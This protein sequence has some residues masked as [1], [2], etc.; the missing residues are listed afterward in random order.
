[1]TNYTHRRLNGGQLCRIASQ[2]EHETV[3]EDVNGK[4]ETWPSDKTHLYA[5]PIASIESASSIRMLIC[6]LD[7][8][9][10]NNLHRADK[11]PVIDACRTEDWREFNHACL[12]D[13]PVAYRV[14]LLTLLAPHYQLMYLTARGKSAMELTRASLAAI[15][16][17]AAPLWMRDEEDHR[18]SADFKVEEVGRLLQSF[19]KSPAD[20]VLMDDDHL[21]CERIAAEFDGCTVILVPSHDASYLRRHGQSFASSEAVGLAIAE[22]TVVNKGQEH[23]A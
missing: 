16:A 5:Y 15:G 2:N 21:I 6:D 10:L 7:G 14:A 12:D 17:P 23:R 13:K 11:M 20:L 18:P 1:M 22:R 19:R 8:T 3:F 4:T 9:L